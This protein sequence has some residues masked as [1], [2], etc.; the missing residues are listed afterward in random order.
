MTTRYC[1][2]VASREHIKAAEAGGFCQF[3]H[4]REAPVRKLSAGD[5]VVYDSPRERMGDG[6][7]IRAFTAIGRVRPGTAYCGEQS[8]CFHPWRRDVDYQPASEALIT[9]LLDQL[10]FSRE[11]TNRGRLISQGFLEITQAD[12]DKIATWIDCQ[13]NDTIPIEVGQIGGNRR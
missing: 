10:S 9:P 5:G 4:G 1:I 7:R 11:N 13:T 2:G 8:G 3:C 6:A 12:F